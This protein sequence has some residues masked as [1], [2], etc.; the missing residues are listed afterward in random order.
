MASSSLS[1]FHD[2]EAQLDKIR[3]NMDSGVPSQKAQAALLHAL[4]STLA[5]QASQR[6][7]VAYFAALFTTLDGT[8]K[9]ENNLSGSSLTEG[10]ILP[11][12]LYLLATV[13]PSVPTTVLRSHLNALLDTLVPLFPTLLPH[14]APLCH[15]I[16][17]FASISI[18]LEAAQFSTPRLRQSF[19]SILELALDSRQK[20]RRKAQEALKEILGSPPPPML[21]HPY[22]EQTASYILGVLEAVENRS[23]SKKIDG[24]VDM[25]VWCCGTLLYIADV[26]PEGHLSTLVSVLLQLPRLSSPLLTAQAF[27]VLAALLKTPK[28][29]SAAISVPIIV[30][31]VIQSP[32]PEAVPSV[33]EAW[34]EVVENSMVAYG[35]S[36]PEGCSEALKVVWS[37][38]WTWL[39]AERGSV[40]VAAEKALGA[41]CRYCITAPAID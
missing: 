26:W 33:P 27:N 40:R 32:P 19:V 9:R 36:D 39:K 8:I 28:F 10:A 6:T 24:A 22:I 2:L 25:G 34:L 16:A 29:S 35:R 37:E 21:R 13:L 20:V 31:T 4:E 7:P 41:M 12:T 15:L 18:H 14:P 5:Q 17:I 1:T 23:I 30:Q 11:A 3:C 38:T